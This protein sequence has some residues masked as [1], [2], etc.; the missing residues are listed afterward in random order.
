MANEVLQSLRGVRRNPG[1]ALLSIVTLALGIGIST[2]VFSVVNGVLLQPLQ[3]PQSDRI[4]RVNTKTT[5]FPN[6]SK[7]TGGDFVDVRTQNKVFDAISV[8]SGGE[9][10]VQLRDRAEFTGVFW[11]NPEFFT[12]FGQTPGAFSDSS[13]VVGEAF[14]ARNFGDPQRA[15][16][17]SI[18]VENRVYEI[19]SVLKGPRFPAECRDLVV[20]AVRAAESESHRV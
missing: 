2:A 6:G 8:Y 9:V 12:I 11:V 18:R 1:F 17:Q 3:F 4:V 19:A 10:G 5:G 14:A 13:A 7:I 20:G 15:L 16:G